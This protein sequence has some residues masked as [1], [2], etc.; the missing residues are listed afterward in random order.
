M[1]RNR[2][3]QSSWLKYNWIGQLVLTNASVSFTIIILFIVAYG[4]G[5]GW[6]DKRILFPQKVGASLWC[7]PVYFLT[8]L[9]GY[10]SSNFGDN[11]ALITFI[12]TNLIQLPLCVWELV[13]SYEVLADEDTMSMAVVKLV[14]TY[15][16]VH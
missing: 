14:A 15:E 10:R 11:S 8:A 13:T 5:S 4:V 6:H 1:H 12:I 7:A 16:A 2:F 9:F 3:A